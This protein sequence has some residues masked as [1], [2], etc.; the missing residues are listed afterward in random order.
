MGEAVQGKGSASDT[1]GEPGWIDFGEEAG[2]MI[3]TAALAC[4]AGIAN[5]HDEEVEAVAGGI[6]LAVGPTIDKVAEDGEKLKE[7]R[8]RMGFGVGRDGADGEPCEP[9]ESS[10]MENGKSVGRG[11]GF[12]RRR[13]VSLGI[14]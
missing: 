14:G 3:P 7:Q 6:D 2:D 9:M 13:R 4:L 5:Q 11:R 8:S 12:L 10:V 1:G